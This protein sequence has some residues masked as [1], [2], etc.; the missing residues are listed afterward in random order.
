MTGFQGFAL[1]TRQGTNL[2]RGRAGYY[3]T[4]GRGFSP[5]P[6]P[7]TKIKRILYATKPRT[8]LVTSR[9]LPLCRLV[10]VYP[11]T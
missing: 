8:A 9:S 3:C 4:V 2:S 11:I 5:A 6:N 10:K 1:E 7:H